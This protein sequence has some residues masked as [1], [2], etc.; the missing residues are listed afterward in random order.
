VEIT[1][2]AVL[3]LRDQNRC[4]SSEAAGDDR[5]RVG[6]LAGHQDHCSSLY[7]RCAAS[8]DLGPPKTM[9]TPLSQKFQIFS[10]AG[11]ESLG[12]LYLNVL[13]RLKRTKILFSGRCTRVDKTFGIIGLD[14]MGRN[15][16]NIERRVPPLPCSIA[17]FP[18]GGGGEQE[19]I[20]GVAK[21][22]N[23]KTAERFRIL[24]ASREAR[25]SH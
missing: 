7:V 18:R 12:L 9:V 1:K 2:N 5:R 19:V 4:P 3:V 20:N 23:D 11:A 14:V 6:W 15:A 16:L 22:K 21:G 24:S 13:Q 25:Q 8:T 10:S 17:R